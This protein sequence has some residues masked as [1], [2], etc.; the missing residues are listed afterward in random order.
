V[1]AAE[2][3]AARGRVKQDKFRIMTLGEPD[4]KRLP[5]AVKKG[6]EQS[7]NPRRD[8]AGIFVSCSQM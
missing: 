3:D 6:I 4:L 1:S 7:E 5:D 2:L 8:P